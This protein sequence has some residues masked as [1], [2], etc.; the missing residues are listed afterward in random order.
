MAD[1]HEPDL[2]AALAQHPGDESTRMVYADYLEQHGY[3]K[4]ARFVRGELDP[5]VAGVSDLRWRA[6]TSRA[7]VACDAADCPRTWDRLAVTEQAR[8]RRCLK[9]DRFA[10][11]AGHPGEASRAGND[12]RLIAVFDVRERDALLKAFDRARHPWKY[13]TY[14]P[15]P[16]GTYDPPPKPPPYH[17]AVDI[18]EPDET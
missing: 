10:V 4:L 15:P 6:I 2:F 17:A 16:P 12:R 8:V 7:P 13:G 3:T 18:L 9:C 1:H 5:S 11:Y 14:N